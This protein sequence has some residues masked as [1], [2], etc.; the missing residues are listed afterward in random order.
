MA[1]QNIAAD[2]GSH[3]R[4]AFDLWRTLNHLLPD[5]DA[6]QAK[7]NQQLTLYVQCRQ[8]AYGTI[9]A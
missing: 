1:D 2:S 6:G 7:I 3:E 4:V 9:P 5:T 8:A